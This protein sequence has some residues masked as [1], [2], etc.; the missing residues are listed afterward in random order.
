MLPLRSFVYLDAT[1]AVA[2]AVH[3]DKALSRLFVL[4]VPYA[5]SFEGVGKA[6]RVTDFI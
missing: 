5:L 2:G 3:R 4:Y 6:L 1:T